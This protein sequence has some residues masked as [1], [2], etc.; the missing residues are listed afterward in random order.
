MHNI[1]T[2]SEIVELLQSMANEK[3]SIIS[4]RFFKTGKGE[5]GEGDLFLGIRNPEVRKVVKQVDVITL[6]EISKLINNQWHEIRLCGFLIITEMFE[7][8]CKPKLHNDIEAIKKRDLLIRFYLEHAEQANNWD[9][10]D[11]SVYKV[12]GRWILMPTLMGSED[13]TPGMNIEYKRSTLDGLAN[14]ECLWLQRMAM[15]ATW[16]TS[17]S[18]DPSWCLRYANKLLHHPH[19]LMH[20]AVGWMLREMGKHCG[21]DC[22]RDFLDTN[23]HEMPRTTLRYA[24][25]KMS[26]EERQYW[27]KR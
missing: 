3:Q 26:E 2:A 22:L 15:V 18:G 8:L 17:N 11:L 1:T 27:L 9:L 24:I 14:S 19:D 23:I 13:G 5:Y 25:E 16:T 7:K 4:M 10:V 21:T 12:I 20:K 6:D